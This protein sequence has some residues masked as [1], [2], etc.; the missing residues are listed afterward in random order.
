MKRTRKQI[1]SDRLWKHWLYWLGEHP[2]FDHNLK[3]IKDY[4][5]ELYRNAMKNYQTHGRKALS[6]D[7]FYGVKP[8][9]DAQKA[10]EIFLTSL[11]EESLEYY[12]KRWGWILPWQHTIDGGRRENI[13]RLTKVA[14]LR[15]IKSIQKDPFDFFQRHPG[16][17]PHIKQKYINY[18]ANE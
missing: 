11:A 17:K 13:D 15:T 5:P 2:A 7:E 10:K 12:C 6:N 3:E 14:I 9:L 4:N 1:K 8:L 18:L 16:I